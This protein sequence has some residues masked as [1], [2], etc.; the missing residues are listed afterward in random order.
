MI[1]QHHE[2]VELGGPRSVRYEP[3]PLTFLVHCALE[4]LKTYKE[5]QDGAGEVTGRS[6]VECALPSLEPHEE[7]K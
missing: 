6:T 7:Y 2:V 1:Y 4:R 3:L 5:R